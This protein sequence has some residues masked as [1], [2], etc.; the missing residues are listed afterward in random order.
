MYSKIHIIQ[1]G[2]CSCIINLFAYL[3][4]NCFSHHLTYSVYSLNVSTSDNVKHMYMYVT[5]LSATSVHVHG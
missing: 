5:Y 4:I 3:C 1:Y 2:I